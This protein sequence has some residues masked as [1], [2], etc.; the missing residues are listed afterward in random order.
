M[1]NRAEIEKILTDQGVDP[2]M[3][4]KNGQT[5]A[6]RIEAAIMGTIDEIEFEDDEDE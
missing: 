6:Q 3:V 1:K 5:A 2:E 4:T